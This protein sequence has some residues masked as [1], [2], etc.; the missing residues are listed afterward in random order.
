M[1][2]RNTGAR[3]DEPISRTLPALVGT[4]AP[5]TNSL[6]VGRR[7][8]LREL[9]A[10]KATRVEVLGWMLHLT[11]TGIRVNGGINSSG[12][13]ICFEYVQRQLR[14]NTGH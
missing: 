6:C 11:G 12:R 2:L 10:M 8:E 5:T 9:E 4:V 14:A 3:V 13:A 1:E 7:I